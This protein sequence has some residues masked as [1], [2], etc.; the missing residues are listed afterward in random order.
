MRHRCPSPTSGAVFW[1]HHPARRRLTDAAI[2]PVSPATVPRWCN[3]VD[4]LCTRQ[5]L[6]G[7][8]ACT[9]MV[10]RSA[11]YGTAVDNV[12]IG[13]QH[14]ASNGSVVRPPSLLSEPDYEALVVR[15]KRAKAQDYQGDG[16]RVRCPVD[17]CSKAYRS[18]S[19][20]REHLRSACHMPGNPTL[21]CAM[22]GQHLSSESSRKRHVNSNACRRRLGA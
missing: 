2:R 12:G 15:L 18:K 5:Q 11:V 22:C 6:R 20:V 7:A 8:A 16:P 3:D 21:R 17:G 1:S 13:A 4:Q 14:A 19:H 9:N 10:S